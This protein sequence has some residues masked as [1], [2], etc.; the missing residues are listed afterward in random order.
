MPENTYF[1]MT[2][3]EL[4]T[5]IATAAAAFTAG[6][7][8]A[9][10]LTAAQVTALQTA[11]TDLDTSVQDSANA[12]AAF[13]EEIQ[14]KLA[15]RE[16]ALSNIS[17][18]AGL[19]YAT[20]GVTDAMVAAAGFQPHDTVPTPIVPQEPTSLVATPNANGTVFLSWNR[21]GN[22]YGVEFIIETGSDGVSWQQWTVTKKKSLTLDGFTPGVQKWFRVKASNRGLTSV[23]SNS[24]AIYGGDNTVELQIAA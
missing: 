5:F 1:K 12:E 15:R 4:S 16:D 18:C 2:D 3:E 8:T 20:P 7:A 13:R 17:L 6:P 21:N 22:P 11:G 10:G 19:M 9:Y 24:A 14:K 23:A